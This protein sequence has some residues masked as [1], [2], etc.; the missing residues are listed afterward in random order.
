MSDKPYKVFE[1]YGQKILWSGRNSGKMTAQNLDLQARTMMLTS[2]CDEL[3]NR[4]AELEAQLLENTDSGWHNLRNQRDGL[5]KR[6][7]ELEE[8]YEHCFEGRGDSGKNNDDR[9]CRHCGEYIT[10][11]LH[12]RHKE[13]SSP[14]P[15]P[16]DNPRG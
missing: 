12:T 1:K 13:P 16:H 2:K 10:S 7:D 8:R 9:F 5:L 4:V 11:N 6:V 15:I 3:S 14:L